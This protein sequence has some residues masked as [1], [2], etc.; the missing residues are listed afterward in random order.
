M[1]GGSVNPA[2]GDFNFSVMEAYL[3]KDGKIDGPLKGATL[4]GNG[5]DIL[6]KI[7]MVGNNLAHGQGMCG[8][9]SGTIAPQCGAANDPC[10]G[11]YRGHKGGIGMELQAMKSLIFQQ[12]EALGF[13]DMEIDYVSSR[14]LNCNVYNQ[15]IDDFTISQDGG[16]AFRG[17][18]QGKM[19]YAYTE[20]IDESA[21][22][23]LVNT[24][25]ENA[26]VID[27]DEVEEIF[28]GSPV[29]QEI[30]LY[31]EEI[32]RVSTEEKIQFLKELEAAALKWIP[33]WKRYAIVA[34]ERFS[35]NGCWPIP[36]A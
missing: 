15:E 23:I 34:M 27:S 36:R 18:Y 33:G 6:S 7:D 28:A 5:P 8:S 19:G 24:A 11:N 3:I 17:L 29:Y 21:V 4:I 10:E 1:G 31:S 20:K 35:I 12:G 14:N 25:R 22:D 9:M 16:L 26:M 32:E 13:T 30:D 2:T